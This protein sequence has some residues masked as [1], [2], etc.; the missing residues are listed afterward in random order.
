MGPQQS[1][2]QKSK[3][4]LETSGEALQWQKS[5]QIIIRVIMPV[6]QLGSLQKAMRS[7][8]YSKEKTQRVQR[9]TSSTTKEFP[10]G[11]LYLYWFK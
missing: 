8:S 7:Q 3:L 5:Q 11:S 10:I 2:N 4:P 1:V 9:A 6:V